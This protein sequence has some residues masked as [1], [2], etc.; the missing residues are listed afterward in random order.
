MVYDE[1]LYQ[2]Q[3]NNYN[4]YLINNDPTYNYLLANP[5]NL[6][7]PYTNN[8]NQNMNPYSNTRIDL[9]EALINNYIKS[10]YRKTY[11]YQSNPSSISS[12]SLDV[13]FK[14]NIKG[15]ETI[16]LNKHSESSEV[17]KIVINIGPTTIIINKIKINYK[18]SIRQGIPTWTI[19]GG[20]IDFS[21]LLI[22][23]TRLLT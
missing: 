7:Y 22:D 21:N 6:S 8:I 9:P 1:W 19:T 16:K 23:F 10:P 11:T 15:T 20:E 18:Y 17:S 3:L 4:L 14:G 13:I 5:T 2:Q 12:I